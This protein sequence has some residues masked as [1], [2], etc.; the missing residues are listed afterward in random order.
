MQFGNEIN[1][2]SVC[3]VRSF[4]YLNTQI[5]TIPQV[6]ASSTLP[7]PSHKIHD[8]CHSIRTA[9]PFSRTPFKSNTRHG[10][11]AP[12]EVLKAGSLYSKCAVVSLRIPSPAT[13]SDTADAQVPDWRRV[14]WTGDVGLP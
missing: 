3:F 5:L 4:I 6:H 1:P 11:D 9:R 13:A 14:F 2:C 10:I 12:E 7:P 8:N